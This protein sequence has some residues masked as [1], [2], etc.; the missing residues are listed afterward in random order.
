MHECIYLKYQFLF[1]LAPILSAVNNEENES[2]S[3]HTHKRKR[4]L[5]LGLMKC[6]L[7]EFCLLTKLLLVHFEE[8]GKTIQ[9]IG[10]FEKCFLNL[11]FCF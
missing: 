9:T 2:F 6:Y 8:F 11:F 5:W 3:V 10:N 7:K 1:S 4:L